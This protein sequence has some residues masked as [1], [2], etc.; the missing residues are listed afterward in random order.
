MVFIP[1]LIM[2]LEVGQLFRDI[3][4]AISVAVMLS[5]MVA[6]TV[7]PALSSRLLGGPDG[8]SLTMMRIPV[9]DDIASASSGRA[10]EHP[11]DRRLAGGLADR[12]GG[13]DADRRPL[14]WTF[15]PKLEYLPD[16]NRNLVFGIVIPPPGYNLDTM[17]EIAT[18]IEGSVRYLWASETGPEQTEEG[19]PKIDQFFFV[20][21]RGNMFVGGSAMETDRAAELIGPMSAPM[22]QE[23]GTFG[24]VSQ[25]S[26]FGRGIGGGRTIDFDIS[27]PDLEQVLSVAL[28][29]T[30]RIGQIMPREEG[31]QFRPDPGLEL[32]APEVR[33]V[34]DRVRLADAGVSARNFALSV[35]AFNDGLR[36]AEITVDG[37]RIDLTLMGP[38]GGR[39]RPRVSTPCRS[40]PPRGRSCRRAHWPPSR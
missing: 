2:E 20:A 5:L 17:T 32:G 16:G 37:S 40:S 22:F 34:P 1:I 15:L 33:L 28:R 30:G 8:G 14:A 35:D 12:G 19:L 13:R 6:V 29:A 21:F 23:P 18:N 31:H 11:A 38:E 24:F 25:P 36:V 26:I 27:G 9:V 39:R 4:V 7:I 3:A 10:R